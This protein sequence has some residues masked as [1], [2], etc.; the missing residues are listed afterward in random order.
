MQWEISTLSTAGVKSTLIWACGV[1]IWSLTWKL[2][3]K[4]TEPSLSNFSVCLLAFIV[5]QIQLVE[6]CQLLSPEGKNLLINHLTQGAVLGPLKQKFQ[7]KGR[8]ALEGPCLKHILSF[9]GV[10]EKIQSNVPLVNFF[11]LRAIAISS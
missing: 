3:L 9:N 8:F 4:K 11:F 7:N 1:N 2:G 5:I 6:F 10:L